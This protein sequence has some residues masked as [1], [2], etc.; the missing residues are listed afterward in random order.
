MAQVKYGTG[1]IFQT[2]DG[3]WKW[4]GYFV[5]DTGKK[6]RPTK[7]FNTEAEALKFQAEQVAKVEVKKAM[8]SRDITFAE[9]FDLWK[10]DVK[11]GKVDISETTRKN[12]IQNIKKHI[13]PLVGGQR[14]KKLNVTTLQ[15]HF[16]KLKK[17]DKKANIEPRSVKTIYNIYTDL[18]QVIKYAMEEGFI[19]EDPLAD[20]KVEKPKQGKEIVNKMT[21][22]EYEAI[23]SNAE[24]KKSYYL[25]AIMF[26]AESKTFTLDMIS[27]LEKFAIMKAQ[28]SKRYKVENT[29]VPKYEIDEY[30]LPLIEEVYEAYGPGGVGIVIEVAT[31]NKNRTAG[32]VRTIFG[33]RGGR[34]RRLPVASRTHCTSR[35][36]TRSYEH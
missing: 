7:T 30:D 35:A 25:P 16:N 10:E 1:T 23:V 24:N 32:N 13:L 4:Q 5:D 36:G 27:G 34:P 33:K 19:Y 20:L 17:G 2:K 3:R 11:A 21:F 18:K 29:V 9:C 31:D 12:T 26:L 15:Q 28:E 6:H 22:A 8:K 14:L